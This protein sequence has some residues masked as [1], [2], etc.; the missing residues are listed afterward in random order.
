MSNARRTTVQSRPLSPLP[1]AVIPVRPLLARSETQLPPPQQQSQKLLNQYPNDGDA[2]YFVY[3]TSP[4]PPQQKQHF[5][6][7]STKAYVSPLVARAAVGRQIG[8]QSNQKSLSAN[9]QEFH[10]PAA[11]ATT[12]LNEMQ[13]PS[14]GAI[15]FAYEDNNDQQQQQTIK[16]QQ[17]K[18]SLL[19]TSWGCLELGDEGTRTISAAAAVVA[20]DNHHQ[21]VPPPGLSAPINR[22]VISAVS[23]SRQFSAGVLSRKQRGRP[24]CKINIDIPLLGNA[25]NEVEQQQYQIDFCLHE[26]SC[27]NMQI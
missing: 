18:Q 3:S 22:A 26:A 21:P 1:P 15:G 8:Q 16:L 11:A 12:E 6:P 23:H 13:L 2:D 24:L 9:A 25:S 14:N 19:S 27:E 4:P 7:E 17:R 20:A 10:P 5:Q